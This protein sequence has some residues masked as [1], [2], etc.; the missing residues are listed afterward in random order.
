MFKWLFRDRRHKLCAYAHMLELSTWISRQRGPEHYHTW[1][2]QLR[3]FI[4][5]GDNKYVRYIN[6]EEART[7]IKKLNGVK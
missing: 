7:F 1:E 5:K 2:N 3:M 6:I 4:G